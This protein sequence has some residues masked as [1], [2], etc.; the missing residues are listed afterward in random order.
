MEKIIA[1]EL[2]PSECEITDN[3]A[4]WFTIKETHTLAQNVALTSIINKLSKRLRDQKLPVRVIVDIRGMTA[5]TFSARRNA[6][7]EGW[8]IDIDRFCYLGSEKSADITLLKL[9]LKLYDPKKFRY[10]EDETEA[11]RWLLS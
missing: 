4:I 3:G 7:K 8:N 5:S 2:E 6:A 11:R 10:L 1:P 9:V